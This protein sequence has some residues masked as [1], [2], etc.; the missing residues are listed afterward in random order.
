MDDAMTVRFCERVGDVSS[1]S[2]RP[3]DRE[4]RAR[5]SVERSLD[6]LHH[7]SCAGVFADLANRADIRMAEPSRGLSFAK[8]PARRLMARRRVMN[9][10][11]TLRFSRVS[12]AKN[13]PMPPAPAS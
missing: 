2:Q 5:A 7:D 12:W 4:R 3:I 13:S 8:Q 1:N 10:I 6:I 9:L 11:A